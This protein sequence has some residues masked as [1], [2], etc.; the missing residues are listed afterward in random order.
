[1]LLTISNNEELTGSIDVIKASLEDS[2]NMLALSVMPYDLFRR[3]DWKPRPIERS[4]GMLEGYIRTISLGFNAETRDGLG[5]QVIIHVAHPEGK[6][7]SVWRPETLTMPGCEEVVAGVD[8]SVITQY[9]KPVLENCWVLGIELKKEY[10]FMFKCFDIELK[11]TLDVMLMSQVLYAGDKI[12]HGRGDLYGRLLDLPWFHQ[13]A[14][15]TFREY[16]DHEKRLLRTSWHAEDAISDDHLRLCGDRVFYPFKCFEELCQRIETWKQAQEPEDWGSK[17]GVV[18]ITKL[19]NQFLSLAALMELRGIRFNKENHDQVVIPRLIRERDRALVNLGFNNVTYKTHKRTNHW[20]LLKDRSEVP[21][22]G[23]KK[24]VWEETEE[25][26][27]PINPNSAKQLKPKLE[28]YLSKELKESVDL[29][30]VSEKDIRRLLN[31]NRDRLS[32]EAK[33]KLNWLLRYRKAC[34]LLS[35]YGEKLSECCSSRGVIHANIHQIGTDDNVS[36]TGRI[37]FVS[38]NLTGIIGKGEFFGGESED[39]DPMHGSDFRGSFI[40]PEGYVFVNA[41]S[42]QE[43]PRILAELTQEPYLLELFNGPTPDIHSAIAYALLPFLDRPPLKDDPDPVMRSYRNDIGKPSGL[44]LV[45]GISEM[46]LR[47]NLYFKTDGKVDW[48]PHEARANCDN[49]WLKLPRTKTLINDTR[50]DISRLAEMANFSLAPFKINRRCFAVEWSMLGRHRRFCLHPEQ[51]KLDDMEL[52]RDYK[53]I[54]SDINV[55]KDRL[56][57]AARQG[58]NMKIQGTSSDIIKLAGVNIEKDFRALGWD[59]SEGIILLVFDEILAQVKKEHA[60]KAKEIIDRRFR[61]AGEMFV[62]SVPFVIE[63]KILDRWE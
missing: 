12:Q 54:D 24:V 20:S 32:S 45:Y 19:E 46:T 42:A 56:N 44:S 28:E 14:E 39:P 21:V 4:D 9:L 58:F 49:F 16:A 25:I 22:T 36:S 17:K 48:K 15:K 27:T 63:S 61:E 57:T 34:Y 33:L 43:E 51:S 55:Y 59:W 3:H 47:D 5:L 37:S 52:H 18:R 62:K 10:Q 26:V 29:E 11:K 1:M 38:P 13:K 50:A 41:D 31:Q 60:D 6:P 53:P 23:I 35:N 7:V 8:S 2:D 30:G 40:P